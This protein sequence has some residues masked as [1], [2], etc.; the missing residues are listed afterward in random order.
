M[1]FDVTDQQTRTDEEFRNYVDQRHQTG[2]CPFVNCY[3]VDDLILKFPPEPMHLID[4]GVIPKLFTRLIELG[5]FDVSKADALVLKLNKFI[6]DEFPRKLRCFDDVKKFKAA[7][8]RMLGLYLAPF[9]F[10]ECVDDI[11]YFKHFMLFYVAYRILMGENGTVTE[12]N[13]EIADMLIKKFVLEF[14]LLYGADRVSFNIH[15]LLHIVDFVRV[16]GPLE[17][18]SAY[19]YENYYQ[20]LRKWL[21]KGSHY[22]EQIFTRWT[23]T[24]GQVLKK[25]NTSFGQT[26]LRAN[27]KD[28][29][30]LLKNGDVAIIHK[31]TLTSA[32]IIYRAKVFQEK[33][34]FFDYPL[35]SQVLDIFCVN[36]LSEEVI[37]IDKRDMKKKMFL[38]PYGNG[39]V[40]IPIIHSFVN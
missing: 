13:L 4:L 22:F 14:P 33:N 27:S 11:R 26:T 2:I 8:G 36:T 35:D 16:Y 6:P 10:L 39:F 28:C 29:C 7:Q 23:Q 15:C 31:K 12:E 19:K 30:V 5:I 25:Q 37:T 40:V 17:D 21:R 24:N 3:Y 38:V 32:G 18:F 9:F 20:L 1:S 34:G